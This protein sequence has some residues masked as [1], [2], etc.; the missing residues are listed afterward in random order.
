MCC[1]PIFVPMDIFRGS[2]LGYCKQILWPAFHN[3][4]LEPAEIKLVV[5]FFAIFSQLMSRSA[6]PEF[7]YSVALVNG[8]VLTVQG[9]V[10]RLWVQARLGTWYFD[11][12]QH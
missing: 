8:T 3:V 4:R 12:G 2:Y 7:M 11:L 9:F 6:K 1:T 10:T 5:Y